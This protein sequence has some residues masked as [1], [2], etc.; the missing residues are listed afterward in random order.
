MELK[1]HLFYIIK[2]YYCNILDSG[3]HK[4]SEEIEGCQNDNPQI[5]KVCMESLL[6]KQ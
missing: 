1:H 6:E 3:T 2:Y 5:T 4:D